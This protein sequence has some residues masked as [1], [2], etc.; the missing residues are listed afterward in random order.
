MSTPLSTPWILY[1]HPPGTKDWSLSSYKIIAKIS[2]VEEASALIRGIAVDEDRVTGAYLCLM[3]EGTAPIYETDENKEGG[4]LTVRFGP[5]NARSFWM[6]FAAHTMC[7]EILA[8]GNDI[9]PT[10][11]HG[12]VISPK[13]GNVIIQ[14][15]TK[16]VLSPTHLNPVVRLPIQ[17]DIL[18]R[19]HYERV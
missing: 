9:D 6:M 12:V 10:M 5:D 13:R 3:R 16:G 14:I 15:W 17:G 19:P 8:P 11:I 2:T 1:E 4:A 7:D 18:Y